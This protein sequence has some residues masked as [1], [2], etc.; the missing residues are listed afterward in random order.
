MEAALA[1]RDADALTI[2]DPD[3][4]A[5]QK[6]GRAQAWGEQYPAATDWMRRDARELTWRERERRRWAEDDLAA[7]DERAPLVGGL[8]GLEAAGE[9]DWRIDEFRELLERYGAQGATV[10]DPCGGWG[11]RLLGAVAVGAARYIACEPCVPTHAALCAMAAQV[12]A[13]ATGA[14]PGTVCELHRLGFEDLALPPCSVDVALTSPPYFNLELYDDAPSQSHVRY[15]TPAQWEAHISD[16]GE[17]REIDV[18][19]N[20]TMTQVGTPLYIAPAS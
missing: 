2:L 10:L 5:G 19:A 7:F 9:E 16:F 12:A 17:S 4:R 8:G 14:T 11:G 3:F 6:Q 15:A 18:N 13:T 1:E 20:V